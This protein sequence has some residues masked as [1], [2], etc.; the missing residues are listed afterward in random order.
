MSLK[1]VGAGLGRTAT[2]SLKLGLERLLGAPCYHMFEV[3]QHEEHVP[4]WHD[5]AL[6]KPVDWEK[7]FEGYAATVDFPSASFWKELS[8]LYPESIIVLSTRDPEKWWKS[9]SETIFPSIMRTQED[10]LNR[11]LMVR[12]IL[13]NRFTLD[14]TNKDA[15]IAAFNAH[16][17]EVRRLAPPER[18][19]E[20][21]ASD[22]WGPLCK[23][24]NLPIPDEPFPQT[25]S[26]EEFIERV[27]LKTTTTT[28]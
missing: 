21:T 25:N 5:A 12:E 14:L 23:A 7:L 8:E 28:S 22:G 10:G 1:V 20:W 27:R 2:N 26:K 13:K 15:C 6:G 11:R 16:N 17:E 3:V 4:I 19:V 24:L 9:A 18:L